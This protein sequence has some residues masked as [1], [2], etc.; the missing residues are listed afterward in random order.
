MS[1]SISGFKQYVEV[2]RDYL[3][4]NDPDAKKKIDEILMEGGK[5]ANAFMD[6][7]EYCYHVYLFFGFHKSV[8][9]IKHYL[10]GREE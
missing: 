7:L 4:K 3:E 8:E 1:K 9:C 6:R 10:E 2:L 5:K